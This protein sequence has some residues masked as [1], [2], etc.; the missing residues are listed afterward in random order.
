MSPSFL[1]VVLA[2]AVGVSHPAPAAPDPASVIAAARSVD[3]LRSLRLADPLPPPSLEAYARAATGE[4]VTGLVPGAAGEPHRAWAVAVL[5]V[6]IEAL[7]AAVND[8][9]GFAG[10]AWGGDGAVVRGQACA[11]G[12]A[13]LVSMPVPL[14]PDRWWV[15]GYRHAEDLARASDGAVR[16]LSWREEPRPPHRL[17]AAVEAVVADGAQVTISRGAW[18]L[19]ALDRG[20]TLVEYQL[21]SDAGGGLPGAL[22]GPFCAGAIRDTLSAMEARAS[23][24]AAGCPVAVTSS[25][26]EQ[27]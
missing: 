21:Q 26:T 19:V 25:L 9:L 4:I 16:E 3:P 22:A 12:R 20:H 2:L 13:S 7:W 1:P 15:V 11:D 5:D 18:L 27:P 17:P 10:D 24:G 23:S 14:F 8:E 6:P